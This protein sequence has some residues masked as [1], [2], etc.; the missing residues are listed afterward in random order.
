MLSSVTCMAY[1][2][3]ATR[4][5][6]APKKHRT[7]EVPKNRLAAKNAKFAKKDFIKSVKEKLLRRNHRE[8]FF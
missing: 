2:G 3:C 4:M 8:S 5:K 7:T 1:V 6:S